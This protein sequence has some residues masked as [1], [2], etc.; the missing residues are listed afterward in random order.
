MRRLSKPGVF[1]CVCAAI[2]NSLE[3][4]KLDN[5]FTLRFKGGDEGINDLANKIT[6]IMAR[7][8]A[9]K[10]FVL[11]CL[12]NMA[13]DGLSIANDEYGEYYYHCILC[14]VFAPP[15]EVHPNLLNVFNA[16][17]TPIF[18]DCLHMEAHRSWLFH[19]LSEF[20]WAFFTQKQP[21]TAAKLIVLL[22]FLPLIVGSGKFK[23]RK[24]VLRQ[25][26][27]DLVDFKYV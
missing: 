24:R 6:D 18:E 4:V 1:K 7:H 19:R 27:G 23:A 3:F 13:A 25:L 10:F 12:K 11:N 16:I 20:K 9:R 14:G 5:G 17:L 22:E 2:L 26:L 8:T 21:L 15:W